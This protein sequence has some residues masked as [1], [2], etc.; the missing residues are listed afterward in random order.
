MNKVGGYR[1]ALKHREFRKM[2]AADLI[3]R[4]GDS[5][6]S[7]AF[8]WLVYQLS[9]NAT[10][11]AVIFGCNMLPTVLLGPFAGVMVEARD[12]KKVMVLCDLVRGFM[13]CLLAAMHAIGVLTP[14]GMLAITL[15]NSTVEAFR[16]PAGMAYIPQLL[17]KDDYDFGL[18]LNSSLSRGM[19]IIGLAAA[20]GIIAWLG[21]GG[22]IFIDGATFFLSA[23][24]IACIRKNN[25]FPAAKAA[26]EEGYWQAFRS[27]L[28]YVKKSPAIL[29]I[30]LMALLLNG[31]M[32]PINA[33]QAPLVSGLYG[34]GAE[35]L[36][37]SGILVTAGIALGS[38]LYPYLSKHISAK[39]L[40][41]FGFLAV[42][43]CYGGLIWLAPLKNQPILFYT[44]ISAI[45]LI[46]AFAMALLNAYAT[47][48]LMKLVKPEYMA[49]T[50]ST[51]GAVTV[52][53]IPVVSF[54][55]SGLTLILSLSYV[56]YLFAI[57][58]VGALI[59][60]IRFRAID[61][62]TES[63]SD[64]QMQAEPLAQAEQ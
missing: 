36:S 35:V 10:W 15:V 16:R 27:G 45:L 32:V 4:F 28:S 25:L 42:A 37:L 19:E 1:A 51:L 56:F 47:I 11:S 3:S 8:A 63:V 9:G 43:L 57:L 49:R 22:A 60:L 54:L 38:F 2:T 31:L 58:S 62:V 26:Q 61:A 39:A 23:L 24:L 17:P 34:M 64:I 44:G 21:I 53:A 52:L 5:V 48:N 12:K 30:C 41:I 14:V 6:D 59:L 46:F 20:A 18:S 7:I 29:R 33:L 55:I 40:F 50:S 13:V